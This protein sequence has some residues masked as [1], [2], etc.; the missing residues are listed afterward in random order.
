MERFWTSHEHPEP[1]KV[2]IWVTEVPQRSFLK[3]VSNEIMICR[4]HSRVDP[5]LHSLPQGREDQEGQITTNGHDGKSDDSISRE[6][7]VYRAKLPNKVRSG[8]V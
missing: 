8:G 2:K 5:P 7:L 3:D 4:G 6:E 1:L